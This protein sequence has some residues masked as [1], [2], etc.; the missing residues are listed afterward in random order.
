LTTPRLEDR[1]ES[2]LT[3]VIHYYVNTAKPV[4]S[5]AIAG[6]MGLSPATVRNVLMDLET[7][8]F[9]THPHTSAGRVP[10]NP[11]YRLYVDKL[12]QARRLN[13]E[14]KRQIE[15]QYQVTRSEVEAVIRHTAKILSAMTNLGGLAA[16]HVPEDIS[17]DHFKLVPIDAKKLMV[18]LV[19]DH[20]L[21]KEELVRLDAAVSFKEISQI[22]QLLNSRF[23][24]KSLAD[25]RAMLLKEAETMKKTRLSIVEST[26]RLIEEALDSGRSQVQ[27]EGASHLGEQPEFKD[28]E[29]MERLLKIVEQKSL[30]ARVMNRF[31]E[32]GGLAVQIG[33]EIPEIA[34]KDFSLVRVPFAWEGRVVGSLGVLGPTRM[35]YE[36]IVSLVSHLAQAL[37]ENLGRLEP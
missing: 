22:T 6:Q 13:L 19:L 1:E 36:R 10:L 18:I 21:V 2:V 7:K 26:L 16:Y 5:Q 14:E 15:R 12:M 17:L 31:P 9:L 8:G 24:G 29:K 34:L 25:L 32:P 11:A 27:L 30:L 20:G 4:S 37:K 23:G 3:S 35:D 28:A 33:S